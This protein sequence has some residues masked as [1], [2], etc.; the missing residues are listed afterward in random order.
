MLAAV[1]V[2]G[3]DSTMNAQQP[4][5]PSRNV[6]PSNR[7]TM[8]GLAAAVVLTFGVGHG[9]LGSEPF[10]L[11]LFLIGAIVAAVAWSWDFRWKQLAGQS[12]SLRL[13][14][15]WRPCSSTGNTGC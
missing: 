15:V 12:A 14:T 8:V 6:Q 3:E 10:I 1:S 13:A 7:G 11:V 9:A 4:S 5:T 2:V